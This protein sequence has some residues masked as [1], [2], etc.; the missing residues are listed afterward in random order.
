MMKVLIISSLVLSAPLS[1]QMVSLA[2]MPVLLFSALAISSSLNHLGLMNYDMVS[3]GLLVMVFWVTLLMKLSQ[4]HAPFKS[5]L[6]LLFLV[7]SLSLILSFSTNNIMMFYFFFEWSLLPI[8]M[9]VIG[10][11]YQMERLRASLFMLFYT[12]F[13]SLPLLIMI[14]NIISSSHI[15][16]MYMYACLTSMPQSG[17]SL[18]VMLIG[19]FLVKFP[20]FFVHQWLPKAHVEAPVGG[21][22]IL[23]G[24]LL[25]LGGYGLLRISPLL[26]PSSVLSKVLIISMWGGG[27]LSAVCVSLSDLKVM[28]AYSSVVHMA[29]IIAGCTSASSWG[30]NGAMI[31][32]IAHG[33]CS[34]GMFSFANMMYE[35]SHSRN[36]VQNKGMLNMLPAMSMMWFMLCVANF[37][38]PFTYNL[39]GEVLLIVNLISLSGPLLMSV[40]LISFFSAA[41]SLILYASTQQG[42]PLGSV[43]SMSNMSYREILIGMSHIWPI[44]LMLLSPSLI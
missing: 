35:R 41:Y 30:A 26:G 8:F 2:I 25:K 14:I 1:A 3:A 10:W 40:G 19:A 6:F 21:S 34:S 16:V 13:A 20:M 7:L 42:L 5:S 17:K 33:V 31:I 29:L 39:L 9:I 38:G 18:T 44:F 23:A 28:I 12:L 24:V 37:G 27:M 22:M 32:M 15:T 36:L 11:G 43:F 4:F